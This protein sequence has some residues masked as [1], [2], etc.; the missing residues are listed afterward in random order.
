[1][2]YNTNLNQFLDPSS[3][4][5]REHC[6]SY[7]KEVQRLG[8]SEAREKELRKKYLKSLNSRMGEELAA[9]KK[10]HEEWSF[11]FGTAL[12]MLS[13]KPAACSPSI[14]EC[15]KSF[16]EVEG[17]CNDTSFISKALAVACTL[18]CRTTLTLSACAVC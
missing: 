4:Y 9:V 8:M 16:E 6:K 7:R 3:G 13:V 15:Y 18:S 2:C 14:V 17:S 10:Q 5:L 1:M 11:A 12:G